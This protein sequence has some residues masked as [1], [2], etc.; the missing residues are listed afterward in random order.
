MGAVICLS[1]LIVSQPG[2]DF[3]LRFSLVFRF[4]RGVPPVR[5]LA[6]RRAAPRRRSWGVGRGAKRDLEAYSRGC[7]TLRDLR[8]AEAAAEVD[9]GSAVARVWGRCER[10]SERR[11]RR[12]R[13]IL[14]CIVL[15]GGIAGGSAGGWVKWLDW[16]YVGTVARRDKNFALLFVVRYK[17]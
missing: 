12:R 6:M 8:A 16:K 4:S 3:G 2:L 17:H 11:G 14:V 13:M 7:F 5:S 10:R 15:L 1:V 9:D